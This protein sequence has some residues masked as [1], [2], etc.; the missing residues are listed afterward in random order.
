MYVEIC[1]VGIEGTTKYYSSFFVDEDLQKR[2]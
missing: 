2:Q 1:M